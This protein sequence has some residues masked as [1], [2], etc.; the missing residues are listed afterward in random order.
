M[1]CDD[2]YVTDTIDTKYKVITGRMASLHIKLCFQMSNLLIENKNE[3]IFIS[4]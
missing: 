1:P 3:E 2:I 4:T